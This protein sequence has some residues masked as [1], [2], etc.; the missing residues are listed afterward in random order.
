[1]DVIRGYCKQCD[2]GKTGRCAHVAGGLHILRLLSCDAH[3]ELDGKS[4]PNW[5]RPESEQRGLAS[6]NRPLEELYT[7]KATGGRKAEAIVSQR[8][9]ES[10]PKVPFT[11]ESLAAHERMYAGARR[12][13]GRAG[14]CET[15]FSIKY[16][17]RAHGVKRARESEAADGLAPAGPR[18]K[19]QRLA[20]R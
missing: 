9:K 20:G 18:R 1:M 8:F 11:A 15:F 5:L 17:E 4:T 19:S 14:A 6:A 10:L 12:A 3:G 7:P 16:L 13:L 2:A